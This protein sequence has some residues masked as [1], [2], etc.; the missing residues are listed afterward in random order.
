[1]LGT[2]SRELGLKNALSGSVLPWN[3]SCALSTYSRTL[4]RIVI[5]QTTEFP[6]LT[7]KVF[8]KLYPIFPLC[9]SLLTLS[10]IAGLKWGGLEPWGS[11]YLITTC[12]FV[13]IQSLLYCLCSRTS[14]EI[15]S[16]QIGRTCLVSFSGHS[17]F[18]T[19]HSVTLQYEPKY[20]SF[21]T[22]II[23]FLEGIFST[24]FLHWRL[25]QAQMSARAGHDNNNLISY[26]I[27][28]AHILAVTCIDYKFLSPDDSIF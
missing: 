24:A 27:Y 6:Q 9:T 18:S 26:S 23:S 1:M 10:F 8:G 13:P 5:F 21:I 19:Q 20:P 14:R 15:S 3:I 2:R 17:V 28:K 25:T 12:M 11:L 22:E 16:D 7:L 4:T